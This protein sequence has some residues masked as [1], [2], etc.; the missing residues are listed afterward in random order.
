MSGTI[1][2]TGDAPSLAEIE[3]FTAVV[4]QGSFS[5]AAQ[6]LGVAKSSV[7][8]RVASLEARLGARLLQRSTRRLALT[9]VGQSYHERVSLALDGLHD[10]ADSVREVQHEPQGEL[11]I[12]APVD[13]G[14]LLAALLAEFS[15]QNPKVDTTV[16]LTQRRVDLVREGFDVALRAGELEDSNLMVR[17]VQGGSMVVFASPDYLAEHGTPT[18]VEETT[19]HP[20]VLFRGQHGRMTLSFD[21]P[22]GAQGA[23]VQGRISGDEFGFVRGAARAGAGLGFAPLFAVDDDLRTGKLVRVLPNICLGRTAL[24]LVYPSRQFV[25]AKVRSF[26]DF[27]LPWFA[28][29][30]VYE[31]EPQ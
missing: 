23:V 1:V 11:K 6:I 5:A 20:W 10:A 16:A 17:R 30:A 12:T 4:A 26:C 24:S 15:L 18:T 2:R 21:T 27:A 7:S 8:R 22:Q 31:E 19:E 9:E 13:L 3:A 28:A 29:R 14:G 25:P